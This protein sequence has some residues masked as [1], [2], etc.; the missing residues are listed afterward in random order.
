M[1]DL[2]AALALVTTQAADD[3]PDAFA[4]HEASQ[5]ASGQRID[6]ETFTGLLRDIVLDVGLSDREAPPRVI[7]T[8]TRINTA[9]TSRY[10]FEGN[11][12]WTPIYSPSPACPSA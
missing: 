11:R 2:I 4:R 12:C 10:Q 3:V 1:L 8:G 7:L 9:N 5:P 6:Y